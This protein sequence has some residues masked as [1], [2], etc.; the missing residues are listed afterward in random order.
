MSDNGAANVK[1]FF[2]LSASD[3]EHTDKTIGTA[4]RT[5]SDDNGVG[6]RIVFWKG[7]DI[8]GDFDKRA[9]LGAGGDDFFGSGGREKFGQKKIS[10]DSDGG[11]G[12]NE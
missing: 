12:K 8:I 9:I 5:G 4:E 11:E 10:E 2:C 7:V 3:G 6:E 1:I